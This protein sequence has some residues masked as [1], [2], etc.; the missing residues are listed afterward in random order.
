MADNVVPIARGRELV[1][2]ETK[3]DLWAASGQKLRA[4]VAWRILQGKGAALA[5]GTGIPLDALERF[6]RTGRIKQEHRAR[7]EQAK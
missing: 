3:C 5:V 7:L 6:V 1:I 2:T 4:G